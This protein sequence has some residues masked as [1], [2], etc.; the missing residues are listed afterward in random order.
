M[1]LKARRVNLALPVHRCP[2]GLQVNSYCHPALR[3]SLVWACPVSRVGLDL[4]GLLVQRE[5]RETWER[6]DLLVS[7]A[8]QEKLGV[9]DL[10]EP[11]EK[12]ASPVGY[13]LPL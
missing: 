11:K 2:R 8:V 1:E 6:S 9:Q 4:Q 7:L 10:R 3:G 5:T 13:V 12:R